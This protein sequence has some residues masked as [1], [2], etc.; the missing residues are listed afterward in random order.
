MNKVRFT[1]MHG[2]GNDFVLIDDRDERFPAHDHLRLAAM[3]SPRTGI[4]CEA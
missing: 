1:K 2:A 4:A 3:A